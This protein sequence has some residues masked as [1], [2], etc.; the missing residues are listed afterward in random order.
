MGKNKSSAQRFDTWKPIDK[1]GTMP[2]WTELTLDQL[3]IR[4]NARKSSNYATPNW[5]N[6]IYMIPNLVAINTHVSAQ[7][8]REQL[9]KL[10]QSTKWHVN[11]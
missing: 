5:N 2:S 11:T 7:Y 3:I 10:G 4:F 1:E 9:S 8:D 6:R